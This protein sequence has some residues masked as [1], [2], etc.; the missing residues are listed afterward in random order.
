M[1]FDAISHVI[2]VAVFWASPGAESQTRKPLE[3]RNTGTDDRLEVGVLQPHKAD[4]DEELS[5]GGY[6][7]VPGDNDHPGEHDSLFCG[8]I[9]LISH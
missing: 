3:A 9:L 2:A 5:L 6:L 7:V 4:E 1:E 8:H